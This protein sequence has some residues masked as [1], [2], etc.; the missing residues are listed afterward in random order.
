MFELILIAYTVA[1]TT[2]AALSAMPPM[3]R[4]I[5]ASLPD[6]QA[7]GKATNVT[8]VFGPGL[9]NLEVVALCVPKAP[10]GQ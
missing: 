3:M 4:G 2:P 1:N 8:Q 10:A 6:C 7:A 5:Y 9:G